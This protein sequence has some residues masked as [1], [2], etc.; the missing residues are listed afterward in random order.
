MKKKEEINKSID[1]WAFY[2]FIN[3]VDKKIG[4]F[5]VFF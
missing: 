1:I 4:L 3:T 5:T 2:D